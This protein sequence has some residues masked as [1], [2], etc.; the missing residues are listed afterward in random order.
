[1]ATI[2]ANPPSGTRDYLPAEVLRLVE[3]ARRAAAG[4]PDATRLARE[5]DDALH[6]LSTFDEGPDL[7]LHYKRLAVL[8]GDE[9]YERPVDPSDALSASQARHVEAQLRRF[10]AWWRAW[11]VKDDDAARTRPHA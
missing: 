5:L 11:P 8:L 4:D 3:L 10:Q 1:M 6:V 7:V 2:D 9:A